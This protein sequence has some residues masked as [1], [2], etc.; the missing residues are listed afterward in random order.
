MKKTLNKILIGLFLFVG[1]FLFGRNANATETVGS[2]NGYAPYDH[3]DFIAQTFYTADALTVHNAMFNIGVVYDSG[4][5]PAF[6][7]FLVWEISS[8]TSTTAGTLKY[9]MMIGEPNSACPDYRTA[10]QYLGMSDVVLSSATQ[11]VVLTPPSGTTVNLEA[12]HYYRFEVM[13]WAGTTSNTCTGNNWGADQ[14]YLYDSSDIISG[15]RQFSDPNNNFSAQTG[16]LIYALNYTPT[17]DDGIIDF[18]SPLVDFPFS[19]QTVNFAGT[20]TDLST[21]YDSIIIYSVDSND[22]GF[23]YANIYD[24]PAPDCSAGV[25]NFSVNEIF[26]G[27]NYSY[28]AKMI[29]AGEY[30]ADNT[31][32]NWTFMI[33]D[34]GEIVIGSSITIYTP[35]ENDNLPVGNL[36]FK[37][38]VINGDSWLVANPTY[39]TLLLRIYNKDNS[40]VITST[41]AM[42]PTDSNTSFSFSQNLISGN[43]AYSLWAYDPVQN[44]LNA[45]LSLGSINFTIGH[46]DVGGGTLPTDY[47]D[48]DFEIFGYNTALLSTVFKIILPI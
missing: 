46:I 44:I 19:P 45:G 20:Y 7:Q 37:G 31:N 41:L 32:A 18:I 6:I 34:D 2:L 48:W 27:G 11:E 40:E 9:N 25:C 12:N 33:P 5:Y 1:V 4:R 3:N 35:L 38:E 26:Y 10:T 47:C 21:A 36:L 15:I 29:K 23:I 30:G 22:N 43:Y 24:I 16:D 14:R 28:H 8:L 13:I 39:D 42:P 17:P